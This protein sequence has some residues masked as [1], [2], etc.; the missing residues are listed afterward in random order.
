[1][2]YIVERVDPRESRVEATNLDFMTAYVVKISI[3]FHIFKTNYE[4]QAKTF[5]CTVQGS[6]IKFN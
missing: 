5:V 3:F 4:F 6:S 2:T 1:M